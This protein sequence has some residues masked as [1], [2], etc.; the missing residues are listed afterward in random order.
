MQLDTESP[1]TQEVFG[2][3][4]GVTQSAISHLVSKGVIKTGEPLGRWLLLYCERLREEAAGRATT[5]LSAER[6]ALA[7]SQREAQ[8]IKNA[9]ARGEYASIALLA[10][11]LAKASAALATKLDG[12]E[13]LLAKVAPDLPED[14]K[15]A[16]L[17]LVAK[18]RNEWAKSTAQLVKADLD[19]LAREQG[20][21]EDAEDSGGL[22][23]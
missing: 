5:E 11:V 16:L 19:E 18:A 10:D 12:I 21:A 1:V 6:A 15:Q 20:L 17:E 7:R 4:V 9:V 2:R 3:L 22:T 23:P 8:E 13:A 14:A